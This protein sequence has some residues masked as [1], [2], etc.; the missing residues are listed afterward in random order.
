MSKVSEYLGQNISG[1]VTTEPAVLEYFSTDNG[2]L[3][4]KPQ[5]VVYPRTLDDIRKLARFA[6]RLAEKGYNLPITPR[7]YGSGDQGAALGEGA[8][9]IFP[10]H[11]Q[12]VLEFDTRAKQIRVQAGINMRAL[13]EVVAT[14]GLFFPVYPRNLKT[15]TLGGSIADCVFGPKSLHYGGMRDWVDQLEIVLSSGEVIQTGRLSRRELNAKKGL[16]TLEGAIYRELDALI[17]DNWEAIKENG[18][19]DFSDNVG[20]NL[21]DVKQD[22]GSFDLTPLI[23]G[24]QGTLAII[25]QAIL[26]LVE[27]PADTSLMV[28]TLDTLDDLDD[29]VTAIKEQDPSEFDFIDGVALNWIY[30]NLG[31]TTTAGLEQNNLA[32]VLIVEFNDGDFK[33]SK[34]MRKISKLLDNNNI[35]YEVAETQEDKE[36]IWAVRDCLGSIKAHTSQGL[37]PV[38]FSGAVVP[39]ERLSDFLK[40]LRKLIKT[41]KI[42]G[43]IS[44][45]I[46]AG[47]LNVLSLLNLERTSDRQAVF[48]MNRDY[49]ELTGKLGGTIAGDSG[50][51]RLRALGSRGQYTDEMLGIF[52]QVKEIF[53]PKGILNPGV[54][55]D[56]D[57]DSLTSKINSSPKPRFLDYRPRV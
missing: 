35:D 45:R 3:R 15:A 48:A 43:F 33:H 39:I 8:V 50:D 9:M 37:Y 11:M 2:I 32:G 49:C 10:A 4:Y 53:D 19:E 24:S 20:Y 36:D 56:T 55:L 7:G 26:N 44:G 54:I 13:Q 46:G 47:S 30:E 52:E 27:R 12:K 17:D 1:E 31:K 29:L 38:E 57:Q 21:A 23:V 6:W 25:N 22:D 28:I 14:H 42:E 51:G 34:S 40:D 5:V 41:R 16:Q 18:V